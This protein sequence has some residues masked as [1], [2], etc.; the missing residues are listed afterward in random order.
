MVGSVLRFGG[1]GLRGKGRGGNRRD[2]STQRTSTWR[3]A[4]GRA[5]LCRDPRRQAAAARS[6]LS[7]TLQL[8]RAVRA[9]KSGGEE[10]KEE[11]E[12]EG[13]GCRCGEV[14]GV[15]RGGVVVVVVGGGGGGRFLQRTPRPFL[16]SEISS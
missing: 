11:E 2:L 15:G 3:L 8:G 4:G 14:R 6:R 13:G 5:L 9:R 16:K 10:E 12:S 1:R 7:G